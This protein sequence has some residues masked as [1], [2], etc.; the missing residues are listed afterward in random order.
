[1][2]NSFQNIHQ[3]LNMDIL[4]KYSNQYQ[5]RRFLLHIVESCMFKEGQNVETYGCYAFC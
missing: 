4:F 2:F 3:D 1:M 5:K